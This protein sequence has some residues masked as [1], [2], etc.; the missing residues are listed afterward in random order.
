MNIPKKAHLIWF[1]PL[2]DVVTERYER[3]KLLN[4]DYE[5]FLHKDDTHLNPIYREAWE[6]LIT[7]CSYSRESLSINTLIF[8]SELLRYSLL[9]KFGG[10]YLD[11]DCLPFVPFDYLEKKYNMD[12]K[13]F[14]T[15][16][17]A[18]NDDI[19]ACSPEWDNWDFVN[20]HIV[21]FRK[22]IETKRAF[23][24]MF[25]PYLLGEL[26][27]LHPKSVVTGG[28]DRFKYARRGVPYIVRDAFVSS[29]KM[30][31]ITDRLEVPLLLNRMNLLGEGAIINA[32]EESYSDWFLK[33]WIGNKL[34]SITDKTMDLSIFK[35][36]SVVTNETDEIKE[37]SLDFIYI[38]PVGQYSD[39]LDSLEYWI[40]KVKDDG[41]ICGS[42][43][44]KKSPIRYA[45]R[46]YFDKVHKAANDD[47]F[48]VRKY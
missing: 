22:H 14:F 47:T 7:K 3:L 33:C 46:Q 8:H 29:G 13:L 37:N 15:Y 19:L 1:G 35:E 24:S 38:N 41:L 39:V 44:K 23:S 34:L 9:Q 12:N 36:R 6:Y 40:P 10:W 28:K 4:P 11:I 48:Y 2:R 30:C 27:R 16:R 32:N 18:R 42:G 5:I 17:N 26:E 45:I 31:S 21:N 43:Y 20:N 25:S